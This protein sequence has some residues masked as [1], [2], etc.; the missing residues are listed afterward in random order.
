MV[1]EEREMKKFN[2]TAVCVPSK[3]Y[4][5]NL[6]ERVAEIKKL[7][8]AG[9]YFTINRARQYGKTTTLNALIPALENEY[10]VLSLDFQSIGKDTFENG[11]AF[12]QAMARIMVD[13][14]EFEGVEIPEETVR[15]LEKLNES[16]FSRVKMDEDRK[17]VV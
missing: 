12:S 6:S 15:A 3:H 17:S 5:V 2:T 14:H 4:M 16:E 7:V 8:D 10:T 9:K 13:A 11:A 1:K